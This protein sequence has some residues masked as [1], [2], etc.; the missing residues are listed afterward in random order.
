MFSCSC[1]SHSGIHRNDLWAYFLQFLLL[2]SQM[3][4]NSIS[5][6]IPLLYHQT[7]KFDCSPLRN[8][9]RFQSIM[10]SEY[11]AV[12][13]TRS[14]SSFWHAIVI[15]P[16]AAANSNYEQQTL[17][18][19]SHTLPLPTP[20]FFPLSRSLVQSSSF[21]LSFVCILSIFATLANFAESL[22]NT[23]RN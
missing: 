3:C 1:H 4:C 18:Q 23:A 8:F 22:G 9:N 12:G 14:T 20:P 17:S 16:A 21:G 19:G 10:Q 7:H 5:L 6:S 2:N 15:F 11:Y 13:Y